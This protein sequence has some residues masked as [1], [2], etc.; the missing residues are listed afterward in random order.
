MKKLTGIIL[1]LSFGLVAF[2]QP[3]VMD[4]SGRKPDWV[5]GIQ[6]DFIIVSGSGPTI[7]D[8]QNSALMII[9]ERIVSS[10]ADNV[11]ATSTMQTEEATTNKSVSS[12]FEKYT[13]N[14]TSESGK[15]PYLQGVSLSNAN[16]FYWGKTKR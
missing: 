12:F 14:V 10:V 5:N 3:K 7:N 13:S 16:E 4:K 11:K 15:V 8:A 2:A 6:K 9:K 1:L